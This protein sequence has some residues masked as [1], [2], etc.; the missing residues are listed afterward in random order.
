MVTT[1]AAS[2]ACGALGYASVGT[3][4]AL[5]GLSPAGPVVGGWFAAAQGAGVA[6]GSWMAFA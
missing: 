4:L 1:A 2:V 5:V 6:A 3:G